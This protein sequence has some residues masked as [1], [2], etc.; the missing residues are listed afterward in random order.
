[1]PRHIHAL[2]KLMVATRTACSAAR[3]FASKTCFGA[4]PWTNRGC[5]KRVVSARCS[6]RIA[7]VDV[8]RTN[9]PPPVMATRSTMRFTAPLR[10]RAPQARG[11]RAGDTSRACGD[12][13]GRGHHQLACLGRRAEARF[14]EVEARGAGARGGESGAGADDARGCDRRAQRA[15]W[16]RGP[17]AGAD[18]DGL[19]QAAIANVDPVHARAHLAVLPWRSS[20]SEYRVN[21]RVNRVFGAR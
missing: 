20:R 17:R 18:G 7:R 14:G 9:A 8:H 16:D 21:R 19:M 13:E 10:T 3:N 15:A 12:V 1:M 4:S 5:F 6:E 2:P 11:G